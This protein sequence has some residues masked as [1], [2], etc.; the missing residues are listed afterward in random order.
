[1]KESEE[2]IKNETEKV[3]PWVA[4]FFRPRETLRWLVL[5]ETV[6]QAKMLWLSFTAV[7]IIGL[8]VVTTFAPGIVDRGEG[9]M[10]LVIAT[11]LIFA[12]S[13]TCFLV[14]SYL[15]HLVSNKLGGRSQIP[16]MRIVTAY[17]TVVPG[18]IFGAVNLAVFFLGGRDTYLQL[19]V[20]YIIM[21]WAL[22][23]SAC[24][25]AAAAEIT[26]RKAL[27]VYFIAALLWLIPS[28]LTFSLM[29]A[30]KLL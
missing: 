25:I 12:L 26:I 2:E 24:G 28:V 4:M 8:F 23:I 6:L 29:S 19:L 3:N 27:I 9:R 11:P 13:W 18:L 1:V 21:V 22:Y 5:N 20:Q 17:T 10:Q 14:E 15:L 7:F 30:L 16:A